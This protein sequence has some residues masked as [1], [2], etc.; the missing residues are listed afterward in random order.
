MAPPSRFSYA[1]GPFRLDPVEKVLFREGNPVSLTPKTIETLTALLE[2]HGHVVTKEELLRTVWPDTFVEENNLAQHISALRRILGADDTGRQFIETVPKRGY[3]FVGLITRQTGADVAVEMAAPEAPAAVE[4]TRRPAIWMTT[5]AIGIVIAL[6]VGFRFSRR[7]L[8]VSEASPAANGDRSAA[9]NPTRIA[10]LPFANLG[11]SSDEYFAAGIT[12]EITSRLAGLTKLAVASSTTA[13]EYDRRGKSVPRIGSDL[14]VQYVVEGSVRWAQD[15]SGAKVRITP[16]LI[17]V[18]DDTA[19]W[20][21]QYDASLAD[22]FSVQADIAYRI[23]EALQVAL[24]GRERHTVEARPTADTEAYLAFLRGI[25]AYQQGGT[26][27]NNQ[28]RAREEL[29]AAVA[30]D[31][32]FASAWSWLARVYL[33]QYGSGSERKPEIRLAAERAAQTAIDLDPRLPEAHMALASLLF[34]RDNER[35]LRELEIARTG[36]PNSPEV[37]RLIGAVQTRRG[38]WREALTAYMHGFDLAPGLIAEDVAVHYLRL[39]QYTEAKR[40]IGIAKVANRLGI[41]VPEAWSLFSETGDSAAARRVL[42]PALNARSPAD[43]RVR[44]LLARFEWFDGHYQRALDLIHDMDPAGAWMAANFRFPAGIAAAQ[45]YETMGRRADASKC[46]EAALADLE[47]RQRSNPDDYQIEAALGMAA[48]GLGR[49]SDA[50]RHGRR[51][52]DLMPVTKDG[53]LGPLYLYLLAQIYSRLGQHDAA[54]ATL[55]KLF[56]VPGFYNEVWVQRDPGFA[57]LRGH[58]AFGAAIE[59]WSKQKGDALLASAR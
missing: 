6:V 21:Q 23:T 32:R 22:I 58:A 31:P 5:A 36:L 30:R 11:S 40:F 47:A 27:T 35:A 41:A 53:G 1:F 59:R 49:A 37:F 29:E 46:Y 15:S 44:G 52:A 4:P 3:R 9:A 34:E 33:T 19:V 18:A 50:V 17:R 12:E 45:V 56:S 16:K 48:A 51:A 13:A 10:V 55:D 28:V 26:D 8:A 42:E 43:A 57:A 25:T 7:P 20:T 38:R 54:F 2:Q 39:R 24:E 14:G